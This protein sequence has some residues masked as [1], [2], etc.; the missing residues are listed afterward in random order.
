MIDDTEIY[1]FFI[2]PSTPAQRQYEALRAYFIDRLPQQTI[3][4]RFGYTVNTVRN[5]VYEFR[6]QFR[7]QEAP[8]F[9]SLESQSL[10]CRPAIK[11]VQNNLT[12]L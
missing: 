1:Q 2:E 8:F 10:T 7:N 9:N 5:M 4:E 3:A 6:Q 11:S 12:I